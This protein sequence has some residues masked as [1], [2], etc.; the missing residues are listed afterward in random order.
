MLSEQYWETV[1]LSIGDVISVFNVPSVA[2]YTVVLIFTVNQ[3]LKSQ[4]EKNQLRLNT[5]R[6]VVL[7]HGI[8]C[9]VG[10]Y[11]CG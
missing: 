10:L 1:E 11:M 2:P 8:Y 6:K 5:F 9:L 7:V 3:V 4:K